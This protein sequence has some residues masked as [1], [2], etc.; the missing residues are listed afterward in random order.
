VV[1]QAFETL[2]IVSLSEFFFLLAFLEVEDK[3]KGISLKGDSLCRKFLFSWFAF[4]FRVARRFEGFHGH[5]RL[6]L[7]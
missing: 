4:S 6:S 2:V 5:E 7:D 3:K 1:S